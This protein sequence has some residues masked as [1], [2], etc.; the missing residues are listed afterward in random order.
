MNT[1]IVHRASFIVLLALACAQPQ[2]PAPR[3]VNRVVSLAPNVTEMIVA[4]GGRARI[5]GTDD[6]SNAGPNVPKVGGVE[7][8]VEKIV[9]LRPDLVI[10]SASNAHPNLRRALGGAHVPLLVIRTERLS[11]IPRAME[12]VARATGSDARK[13]SGEFLS[14]LAA[15]RRTRP[16]AP[17]ILFVVWPDPMYIAGRTTFIDDL[18][19]LAGAVNAAQVDGWPSYSLEAFVANPPDVVLY[20]SRSVTRQAIDALLGRAHVATQ[21]VAVDEDVFT[22]PG[23]RLAAAAVE[24]NRICDAWERAH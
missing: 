15:N 16:R 19:D 21:A 3:S 14:A 4:V 7:P 6:F 9:A 24:L 18:Y 17:R 20:P 8:D 1:F 11:D 13:A 12:Q 2:E 10:A 23:P 22:R 5:A